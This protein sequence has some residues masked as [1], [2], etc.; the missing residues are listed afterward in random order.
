MKKIITKILLLFLLIFTP[1]VVFADDEIPVERIMIKTDSRYVDTSKS[2]YM[3][4]TIY[5][6]NATNKEVTWSSSDTTIATINA[7][8]GG[9]STKSK[10]GT[11]TIT[12]TANDG[13]GVV[14]SVEL[15]VGYVSIETGSITS[16]Q[17]SSYVQ[18]DTVEWY[19][20]DENIL[21]RTGRT[22]MMS[23]NNNYKHSI[24]VRGKSNGSVLVAMHTISGDALSLSQVYVYTPIKQITTNVNSIEFV[25]GDTKEVTAEIGPSTVSEDLTKIF[26]YTENSEIAS[27]DENGVVTAKKDGNTNLMIESQYYRISVAIPIS[28]VTYATDLT[29]SSYEVTL[30]KNNP[31]YQIEFTVLPEE[32]TY[33]QV[34]YESLDNTIA[35]V[36]SD[37]KIIALKE[38]TTSIKVKTKDKKVEKTIDVIIEDFPECESITLAEIDSVVY[39]N[40]GDQYHTGYTLSPSDCVDLGVTWSVSNEKVATVDENGL[41]T[42]V[43]T[44]ETTLTVTSYNGKTDTV[45]IN[46]NNYIPVNSVTIL[47]EK[48]VVT[49]SSGKPSHQIRYKINPENATYDSV[50]WSIEDETV[51][52]IDNYGV[53]Y[54]VNVGTTKAHL[55]TVD[56]NKEATVDVEVVSGG[57]FVEIYKDSYVCWSNYLEYPNEFIIPNIEFEGYKGFELYKRYENGEFYDKY[58]DGDLKYNGGNF[59]LYAKPINPIKVNSLTITNDY[60]ATYW[61]NDTPRFTFI[62]NDGVLPANPKVKAISSDESVVST[63]GEWIECYKSELGNG[64]YLYHFYD[65]NVKFNKMGRATITLMSQDGSFTDTIV[66]NAVDYSTKESIFRYVYFGEYTE[67]NGIVF[68]EGTTVDQLL[69]VYQCG[70]TYIDNK[71]VAN[72]IFTDKNNNIVTNK[73]TVITKD[74]KLV[75][76]DEM[77]NPIGT[78]KTSIAYPIKF[79]TDD[80]AYSYAVGYKYNGEGYWSGFDDCYMGGYDVT[81]FTNVYYD[82]KLVSVKM[83]RDSDGKDITNE[84]VK[85]GIKRN[86]F[87]DIKTPDYPITIKTETAS[88]RLTTPVVSINKP[89]GNSIILDIKKPEREGIEKYII[90]RSTNGKNWS[91]YKEITGTTYTNTGLTYGTTYY[92][93]VKAY[94]YFTGETAYSN[95]VKMK[96][97]PDKVENIRVTGIG[98]K[99]IKISWDKV[100]VTGYE[101]YMNNKKVATI[102]KN[103]TLSYNKTKLSSNK[104]YSFKVRA[105][106][107]VKGKKIYG[108]FSDTISALTAPS[109][110]K[111]SSVGLRDYNAL[112]VNVKGVSGAIRYEI[113][114]S[115]SKKGTYTKIG[116][117]PAAGTYVDN[118]LNTGTTY[119]YK[120]RAC[121]KNNNCTAYSS[122]VSKK[123]IPL[124]PKGVTKVLDYYSI[125]LNWNSVNG[126]DGYEIQRSTNKKRGY[127]SVKTT[128]ELE[129]NNTKLSSNKTYYYKIRAYRLVNG[130]KIYSSFTSV[131][132][133]KTKKV[134]TNQK[135]ALDK[136]KSLLKSSSYSKEGLLDKLVSLKH[137]VGNATFAINYCG[138]NWNDQALKKA[139]SYLVNP[140]LLKEELISQLQLDKFTDDQINY[141]LSTLGM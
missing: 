79:V 63:S 42:A 10:S 118:N 113:V 124:T 93:K 97:V 115:T 76:A 140:E 41:V 81:L 95:V 29:L 37:G 44:G 117:L 138:A 21:E 30:N 103:G 123:V 129:F 104:T 50:T 74:M 98:Q 6:S 136:A 135:K 121:N 66:V 33:K 69:E 116:E 16:I 35:K 105:Y 125:K 39:M 14:G 25:V 78:I 47:D 32:A 52:R 59:T 141:A 65:E 68:K 7:T 107:T 26:F 100:P 87:Y 36:T 62:F 15:V 27:V 111:I 4:A 73:N 133:A 137:S 85:D 38:G 99:S 17:N 23:I 67:D 61:E 12:A 128:T 77:N 88:L 11:V 101:V 72:C 49:T 1:I 127:K 80:G 110:P 20:S 114:R 31:E 8:T 106:K 131:I 40:S 139:K 34:T 96:I 19:I 56:G 132:T 109:T 90:Y 9:L 46:V 28:V 57:V 91:K 60:Y 18:Y 126:A 55:I 94:N 75:L 108:A 82:Y 64:R 70:N 102:S 92:Y 45:R 13:S 22:G 43:G 120:V 122:I 3:K 2:M 83:Y 24:E 119:Y 112:N 71:Y 134:S 5:P 86:E 54:A 48:V 89:K 58:V 53:I 51:A 84:L 130:K